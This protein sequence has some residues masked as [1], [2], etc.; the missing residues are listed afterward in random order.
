MAAKG[1]VNLQELDTDGYDSARCPILV[2]ASAMTTPLPDAVREPEV[3]VLL[4][5]RQCKYLIERRILIDS[6]SRRL[7]S[8]MLLEI[9]RETVMLASGAGPMPRAKLDRFGGVL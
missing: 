8:G 4:E 6:P 9:H 1:W 5:E 2:H 3:S 7:V